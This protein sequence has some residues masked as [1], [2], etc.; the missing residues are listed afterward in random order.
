MKK[1]IHLFFTIA[2]IAVLSGCTSE[3]NTT[4][5]FPANPSNVSG[6]SCSSNIYNCDDFS[7]YNEAQACYEKCGGV[8]NDVHQLDRDEDGSACETLPSI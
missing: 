7:S 6:C 5:D 3:T 1:I 4:T 2:L 8:N